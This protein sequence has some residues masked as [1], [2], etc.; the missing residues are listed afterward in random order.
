[1]L[2][3][4]QGRLDGVKSELGERGDIPSVYGVVRKESGLEFRNKGE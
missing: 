4:A 3:L 2:G 1:M